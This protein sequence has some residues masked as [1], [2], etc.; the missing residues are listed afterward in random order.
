MR[1]TTS[2]FQFT[3]SA[4]VERAT[5][6]VVVGGDLDVTTTALLG[7][8]VGAC[9]DDRADTV[10]LDLRGVRFMDCAGTAELLA[11][12]S[13]ARSQSARLAVTHTSGAVERMLSPLLRQALAGQPGQP[14]QPTVRIR[15]LHC[16][17]CGT[18]TT[19][20]PGPV[21]RARDGRVL[22]RWWACTAC[23]EGHTLA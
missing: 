5:G 22:L 4:E 21:T 3:I 7:A 20:V 14:G 16:L 18:S 19:H 13:R 17:S 1:P 2:A 9:L 10:A 12:R 11:C 6:V 23:S 8:A 15:Q